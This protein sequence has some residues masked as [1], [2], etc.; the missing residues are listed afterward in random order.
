MDIPIST[1]QQTTILGYFNY[2]FHSTQYPYTSF[3]YLTD[4]VDMN[5]VVN[6]PTHTAGHSLNLIISGIMIYIIL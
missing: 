3:K 5:Q 4:F 2:H 1:K 6:C